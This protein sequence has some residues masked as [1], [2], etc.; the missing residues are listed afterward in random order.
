MSTAAAKKTSKAKAGARTQLAERTTRD[1]RWA[2][3]VARDSVADGTFVYSVRTTGVFCRPSCA[4][5]RAR[6]ENVQFHADG[7]AAEAAGFRPCRRCRPDQPSLAAQHAALVTE[8][9]RTIEAAERA[10]SLETLAAAAGLSPF[11]F[12]R[13]FRA[14]T[15][16]TPRAYALAHRARRMRS[17]LSAETTVTRAIY[18]SGYASNGRFYADSQQVL[19]M[20]PTD[21]RAGGAD[22]EIRFAIGEC[23]LGSILVA[24]SPQGVCAILLGDDPDQ[25]ARELQERFPRAELVGGDA[26][27]EQMV[28]AVVGF[29]E[30]PGLGLDLPLDV[31]GTAFQQRV[32]QA[33]R[34]IPAGETVTYADLARRIGAPTS[35]RAVAQACATN[36]LAVAI[37]CHRVVRSDGGLSGYRW[38]VDRKR[39]LIAR[40]ARGA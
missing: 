19:G 38:G 23:S 15:G 16:L 37:P 26:E 30:H 10:P 3:V 24:R 29:V 6:P 35:A 2:A 39:T 40:E 1:P 25:L 20:T 33:L 17:A 8:A 9:C 34:R 27:F 36:L 18:E 32:W 31:R 22:V 4:S 21:F 12:H 5:R 28:A 7:A 13:I 14:T 11:H